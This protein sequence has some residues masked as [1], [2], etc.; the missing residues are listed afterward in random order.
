MAVKLDCA[1]RIE[2][3]CA[4]IDKKGAIKRF[5]LTDD[6]GMDV[7]DIT[8][9]NQEAGE[10]VLREV[11]EGREIVGLYCNSTSSSSCLE[12]LGLITWKPKLANRA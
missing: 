2:Q 3:V 6:Q 5:K 9:G 4:F 8:L 11:P 12:S 7:V 10:W 1:K